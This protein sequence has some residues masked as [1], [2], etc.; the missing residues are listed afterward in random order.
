MGALLNGG[1]PGKKP[2]HWTQQTPGLVRLS[3]VHIATELAD[4][5]TVTRL[6]FEEYVSARGQNLLRFAFVLAGDRQVAQDITQA[7][8]TNAFRRWEH[9]QSVNQ[10]EAYVRRAIVNEYLSHVRRIRPLSWLLRSSTIDNRFEDPSTL[11][12]ERDHLWKALE[13]LPPRARAV[14]VLRY[15][16]DA[17]DQTIADILQIK[18]STVR[19][20]AA[21]ALATL[22]DRLTENGIDDGGRQEHS[23]TGK[24][25]G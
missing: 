9:I 18:A 24:G 11:I 21:R 22:R 4:G 16:E 17:D 5:E 20:T 7:A 10:P 6:D 8:L 2:T 12:V 1:A 13:R 25:K 3:S 19:S 14:M 23:V 15:Y